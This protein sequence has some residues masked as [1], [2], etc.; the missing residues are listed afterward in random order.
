[1][2]TFRVRL[3]CLEYYQAVPIDGFDPLV[4]QDATCV[5]AKERHRVSVIRVFGATETGQKVP[6]HVHR[7]LQYTY[8]EFSGSSITEDVEVAKGTL[9]LSIDHALAVSYRKN[10]Y[11]GRHHY[12]GHIS[13]VKGVPFYGFNVGYKFYL[14][15]YLLN[16]LH[17]TRLADLLQEGSHEKSSAT[18][19]KPYAIS[20]T[21]DARLQHLWLCLY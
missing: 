17:M 14:K 19:R 11:E 2:D 7:V 13:L 6:M 3:I 9:Q 1:M 12:V 15:I 4:P 8:L 21:V 5:N 20:G 10:I 16:P 18:I